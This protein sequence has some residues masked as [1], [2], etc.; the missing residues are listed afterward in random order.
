MEFMNQQNLERNKLTM[1]IT[2]ISVGLMV[3]ASVARF[4]S[5]GWPLLGTIQAIILGL[6]V[7]GVITSYVFLKE[8]RL[9][10][11]WTML[12]YLV[13]YAAVL[14]L[15]TSLNTY[16][17]ILPA[18]FIAIMYMDRFYT[19]VTNGAVILINVIQWIIMIV[20]GNSNAAISEA[21]GV[22]MIVL[23]LTMYTAIKVSDLLRKFSQQEMA[24]VEE[25]ALLQKEVTDRNTALAK[26]IIHHFEESQKQ[27][28]DLIKSIEISST[29]IEEI[30]ASCESTAE[31]IQKQ[32]Q[33]T[34]EIDTNVKNADHEIDGVLDIS[35]ASKEM[36]ENGMKLIGQ[37]KEKAS[38]V[39]SN[40]DIANGGVYN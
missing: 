10:I 37:L 19:I 39:Q 28:A 25:K 16:I 34:Y 12:I 29:A 23:V 24:L 11:A 18:I 5:K 8:K 4:A 26:K 14:W 32:N 15:G 7:I 40:S 1:R 38:I 35:E 6:S 2:S 27:M 31:A 9:F 21:L 3:L 22:R 20:Q 30:A 33:M 17:Y 13:D 36:I